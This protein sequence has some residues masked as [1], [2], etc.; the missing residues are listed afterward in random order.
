M[1]KRSC[2]LYDIGEPLFPHIY[3]AFMDVLKIVIH[4]CLID[5][6]ECVRGSKL[7]DVREDCH[8][9]PIRIG[10]KDSRSRQ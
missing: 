10:E 6:H 7:L 4:S 2:S 8:S 1:K 5:Q 9:Y 3:V